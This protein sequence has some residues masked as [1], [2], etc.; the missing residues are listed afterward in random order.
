M[1]RNG[2]GFHA[3]DNVNPVRDVSLDTISNEVNSTLK[4]DGLM[5]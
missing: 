2:P 5:A 1:S 3:L 4:E